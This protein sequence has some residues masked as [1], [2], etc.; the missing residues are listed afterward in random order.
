[1]NQ[2][3]NNPAKFANARQRLF[4]TR[5]FLKALNRLADL[6]GAY[7]GKR[8][9]MDRTDAQLADMGMTRR[10]AKRAFYGSRGLRVDTEA[11][12]IRTRVRA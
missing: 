1:M 9:L 10:D 3:A 2:I 11:Q 4:V 12:P 8:A 5:M 7:R 6:D